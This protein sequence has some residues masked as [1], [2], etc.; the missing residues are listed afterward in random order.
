MVR[1][2]HFFIGE[3]FVKW[4]K[5]IGLSILYTWYKIEWLLCCFTIH[6]LQQHKLHIRYNLNNRYRFDKKER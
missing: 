5:I 1:L 6:F 3:N 2:L 4:V